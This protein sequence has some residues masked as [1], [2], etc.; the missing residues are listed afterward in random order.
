MLLVRSNRSAARLSPLR[1]R[2]EQ[3]MLNS[4]GGFDG[5]SIV[6]DWNAW[7]G[8]GGC[9]CRP[10]RT[11]Q[12]GCRNSRRQRNPGRTR[13]AGSNRFRGRG[14][15]SR[16]GAGLPSSLALRP[17]SPQ[18]APW[19]EKGL[20]SLLASWPL[21]PPL[22][23]RARMDRLLAVVQ[24]QEALKG[25]VLQGDRARPI[26]P[27]IGYAARYFETNS[28]TEVWKSGIAASI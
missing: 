4:S 21:A 28:E 20:P 24:A 19:V 2:E 8:G 22:L 10:G 18:T 25:W 17:S 23:A 3:P 7:R 12:G 9:T 14:R 5:T 6:S 11:K 16:T 13:Q 26:T 15:S 27:L 1:V